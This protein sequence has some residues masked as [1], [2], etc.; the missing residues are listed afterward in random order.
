[1]IVQSPSSIDST[2]LR[3]GLEPTAL[4]RGLEPTA[5]FVWIF[6]SLTLLIKVNKHIFHFFPGNCHC[7]LCHIILYNPSKHLHN[8]EVL[9]Q[10]E[11][12]VFVILSGDSG[13]RSIGDR[14]E[15]SR[16]HPMLTIKLSTPLNYDRVRNDILQRARALGPPQFEIAPSSS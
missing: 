6:P 14:L 2:V 1:M 10:F 15:E 16:T 13:Y 7:D 12:S 5:L 11:S 8:T 4:S 9:E 3:S